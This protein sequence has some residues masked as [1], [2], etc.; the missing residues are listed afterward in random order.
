MGPIPLKNKNWRRS[1]HNEFDKTP[2]KKWLI[3]NPN[4]Y[5][6]TSI[7]NKKFTVIRLIQSLKRCFSKK[8]DPDPIIKKLRN[9]EIL[10]SLPT[11]IT[12]KI[13]NL[14][15]LQNNI[16]LHIEEQL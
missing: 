8:Q 2:R 13:H 5:K 15:Q 3:P 6:S 12:E 11:H 9:E 7:A 14:R 16:D 1:T 4:P 10:K